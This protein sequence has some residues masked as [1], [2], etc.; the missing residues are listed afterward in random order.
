MATLAPA[1]PK[2]EYS[3]EQ[4]KPKIFWQLNEK[5][6]LFEGIDPVTG[7]IVQ[8]VGDLQYMAKQAEFVETIIGGRKVMVQTGINCADLNLKRLYP[9]SDALSDVICQKLAEGMHWSDLPAIS[10]MPSMGAL[11]LWKRTNKDFAAKVKEAKRARAESDRDAAVAIGKYSVG[12]DKDEI[13]GRKLAVETLKWSAEKDDPETF[14]N[15]VKVEGSVSIEMKLETGI[16]RLGDEGAPSLTL[17]VTPEKKEEK[18]EVE[19]G[20]IVDG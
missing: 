18:A 19:D 13:P 16:R 20:E 14:G 10:G 3:L 2:P 12:A 11:N 4:L 8:I 7:A 5:T 1:T 15:K 6:N 9:F 17:D